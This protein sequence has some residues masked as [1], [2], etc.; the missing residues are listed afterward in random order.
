M[1]NYLTRFTEGSAQ[2][3]KV[4]GKFLSGVPSKPTK[5]VGPAPVS[6]ENPPDSQPSEPSK[7]PFE[8]SEGSREGHISDFEGVP[9][10]Y[11]TEEG[12]LRIP[13]NTLPRFRWWQ[14]GGQSVWTTLAELGAPL[15]TW[16]RHA[17]NR[18]DFLFSAIHCEWCKGDV[19]AGDGFAFCV[20]CGGYA[21]IQQSK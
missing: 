11:L 7:A 19:L 2:S 21:E 3:R 8:G 20:E 5:A 10:P 15:G 18:G 6:F 14:E 12:E 4:F 17:V 1:K 9:T 16:R 13:L